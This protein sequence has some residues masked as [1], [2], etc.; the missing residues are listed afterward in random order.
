MKDEVE[1][2]VDGI[3]DRFVCEFLRY[4]FLGCSTIDAI[5]LAAG[6]LIHEGMIAA[7]NNKERSVKSP[8]SAKPKP[9]KRSKVA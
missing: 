3:A 6:K 7:Q 5:D 4:A 8:N 1:F 9:R 2:V